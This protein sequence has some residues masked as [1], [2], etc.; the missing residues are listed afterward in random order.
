M[1]LP[2]VYGNRKKS[3]EDF[4]SKNNNYII[5][6]AFFFGA[7]LFRDFKMNEEIFE[8]GVNK[9]N[10]KNYDSIGSAAPRSRISGSVYTANDSPPSEK[11]PMHHEMAQQ[12]NPPSY[13]FF[14]C[15]TPATKFGETPIINSKELA[16]FIKNKHKSQF[17]KLK[18]GV[19]YTR[20]MSRKDNPKSALGRGWENTF[21][22]SRKKELE[23]F[24]RK[25]DM[26]FEWMEND[27]LKVKTSLVPAIRKCHRT[28]R[29]TFFN[30]IIAAYT[31]WNDELNI[32]EKS[33]QYYDNSYI[34][35]YFVDDIL[36]YIE[37]EKIEF[38]W[39]KGDVLMIDNT[40]MMHSRNTYVPPRK[41]YTTIRD[42]PQSFREQKKIK[43]LPSWDNIPFT[44]FGTWKLKY[45]KYSVKNA[46]KKGYTG[47]DCASDY[48]NEKEVGE[49]IKEGLKE[50]NMS[51][52][53][54]F[55]TNKLWNTYHEN[56]EDACLKSLKEMKLDYFDLYLVHFPIS[57]KY[58]PFE[59]K[60]PPGWEYYD[61]G[62]Q[63][64]KVP[65]QK[66]WSQMEDLVKNGLVKNIG[67]CNFP[68]ALL[69]D[70]LSYCSIPPSVV[71]VE[72]HPENSQQS[73]VEFC[74][75][76]D[77]H[78]SAFS[79]LGGCS[80]G[81]KNSLI[82]SEPIRNLSDKY[83]CTPAQLLLSW[84]RMRVITVITKTDDVKHMEENILHVDISDE[85]FEFLNS[86]NKNI[87]YNDPK[88]FTPYWGG[89][90]PIHD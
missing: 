90:E 45:P 1:K 69:R 3:F 2:I 70:L 26:Q 35:K 65:M 63:L 38:E 6:K 78:V 71:Q 42:Y 51:R 85:D 43:T 17:L 79:P 49:G 80:Y 86:L 8:N 48:N 21:G 40:I 18:K 84:A 56:V 87:R 46:I 66:V 44:H 54:I 33:V 76:N 55:V 10:L 9:F 77:I 12:Q 62:M 4:I 28:N 29:E 75:N 89:F 11:I 30:S 60:Y 15:E 47:I 61:Q 22:E 74:K 53:D 67:V 7:V 83:M 88:K 23:C 25:S 68:V 73:L 58:I 31:G 59:D 82:E 36:S 81:Q 19:Y 39:K 16:C 34:E 20:V 5:Q 57:L 37:N 32:G 41:L 24:L 13:I 72:I 52:K 27:V 50:V 64:S 14:N